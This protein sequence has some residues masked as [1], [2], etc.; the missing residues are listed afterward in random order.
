MTLPLG[1]SIYRVYGLTDEE[2]QRA[3]DFLQGAVYCW[4]KNRPD[5]WFA[6][7]D[8]AGGENTDWH[9]TPLQPL[10]T[11][12]LPSPDAYG[13]AA[14]DAGWLLKSVIKNDSRDFD[15]RKQ[16]LVRHYR[17]LGS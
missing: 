1:E 9:G 15:T 3:R 16:D 4:C 11:K 8:L 14:K 10:Y 13:S 17:W 6:L 7:R 12:H 2:E 5:E